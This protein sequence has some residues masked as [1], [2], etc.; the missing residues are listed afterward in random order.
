MRHVGDPELGYPSTLRSSD[1]V[2]N[3]S[4][5]NHESIKYIQNR[6]KFSLPRR[7]YTPASGLSRRIGPTPITN[8]AT[9]MSGRCTMERALSLHLGGLGIVLASPRARIRQRPKLACPSN[10]PAPASQGSMDGSCTAQ[11]HHP[12]HTH[13]THHTPKTRRSSHSPASRQSTLCRAGNTYRCHRFTKWTLR[14]TSQTAAQLYAPPHPLPNVLFQ[15]PPT[16][17]RHRRQLRSHPLRYFPSHIPPRRRSTAA[18]TLPPVAIRARK[19]ASV[20]MKPIS[21]NCEI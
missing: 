5:S 19:F 4:E 14:T 6:I 18:L 9:A 12:H 20:S 1:D 15:A 17:R 10:L 3:E 13:S 2:M 11:Q 8:H 16:P 21:H 7:V